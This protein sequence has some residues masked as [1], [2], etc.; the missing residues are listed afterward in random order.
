[1]GIHNQHSTANCSG[2]S[3]TFGSLGEVQDRIELF[4]STEL[5]SIVPVIQPLTSD[6][7]QRNE[8]S[9]SSELCKRLHAHAHDELFDFFNEAP[10]N[11]KATRTIDIEVIPDGGPNG[12]LAGTRTI[13]VTEGL[14]GIEAK[15]LPTPNNGSEIR[16][17]EYVV[18]R[19]DQREVDSKSI[20]GGIERFKEGHHSP[21]LNR[22]AIIAFVQGE[23]FPHWTSQIDNWI[24]EMIQTPLLSH[25]APWEDSDRL[26]PL[27]QLPQMA[28]FQ[29][30]SLRHSK[31]PISLRHYWI[32]IG[33]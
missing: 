20:S 31:P 9:L 27:Q 29:S 33:P 3:A 14:Y 32:A 26:R 25:H 1:M 2:S 28:E 23:G 12:I 21:D 17:R 22:S 13:D 30:V 7:R 15:R 8:R 11:E 24:N 5:P 10:Q 18:G 16:E 6:G 4:L 19:W